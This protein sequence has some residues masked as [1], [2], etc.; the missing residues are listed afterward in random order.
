MKLEST[1]DET[2][3]QAAAGLCYP[4]SKYSFGIFFL[5]I[6]LKNYHF[7]YIFYF[8]LGTLRNMHSMI[9]SLIKLLWHVVLLMHSCLLILI[10]E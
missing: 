6:R 5:L 10:W 8:L 9:Y 1:G 7:P 3:H 4:E 2:Y